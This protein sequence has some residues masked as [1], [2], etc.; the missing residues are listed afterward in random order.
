MIV[1]SKVSQKGSTISG[2]ILH[3]VVVEVNPGYGPAPGHPGNGKV[4]GSVC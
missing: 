2:Q 4:I 1:S 3:I